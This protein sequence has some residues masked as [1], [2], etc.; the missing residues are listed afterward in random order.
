GSSVASARGEGAYAYHR[1]KLAK[2]FARFAR[3]AC[4]TGCARPTMSTGRLLL[5][6]PPHTLLAGDCAGVVPAFAFSHPG[7]Q[8]D[9][10]GRGPH[11]QNP[12][13]RLGRGENWKRPL[14]ARQPL[15][16]LRPRREASAV[17]ASPLGLP[18]LDS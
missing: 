2:G 10:T 14:Y 18:S 16:I 8:R 13:A 3:P 11:L 6:A 7:P 4:L 12:I 15:R 1:G 5:V 17:T 9:I